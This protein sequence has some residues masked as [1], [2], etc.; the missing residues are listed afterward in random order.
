MLYVSWI[1]LH[2]FRPT[3]MRCGRGLWTVGAKFGLNVIGSTYN[4]SVLKYF[5]VINEPLSI[6]CRFTFVYKHNIFHYLNHI[7][8]SDERVIVTSFVDIQKI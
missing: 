4:M 8:Y 3:D 5:F 1:N 6:L 7:N 2:T